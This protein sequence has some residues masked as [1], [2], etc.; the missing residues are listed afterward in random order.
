MLE[1]SE[2]VGE[3]KW[4]LS[5]KNGVSQTQL[6]TL[7]SLTL[8]PEKNGGEAIA[9]THH[10]LSTRTLFGDHY[11]MNSHEAFLTPI[12]SSHALPSHLFLQEPHE[13]ALKE[14]LHCHY[15]RYKNPL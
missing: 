5:E 12:L 6:C 4:S 11:E 9:N 8:L 14:L 10:K 3:N 2:V 15:P 13:E 1:T 7:A